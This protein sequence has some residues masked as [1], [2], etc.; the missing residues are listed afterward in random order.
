MAARRT[1]VD[2]VLHASVWLVGAA[3]VCGV[4]VIIIE[5]M[6]FAGAYEEGSGTAGNLSI[7]PPPSSPWVWGSVPLLAVLVGALAHWR[8]TPARFHNLVVMGGPRR[9]LVIVN[10]VVLGIVAGCLGARYAHGQFRERDYLTAVEG[11][12]RLQ[13]YAG[14]TFDRAALLE[15]GHDACDWL[16]HKRW[17][18]PPEGD[19]PPF[20]KDTRLPDVRGRDQPSPWSSWYI[21]SVDAQHPGAASAEEL[22]RIWVY[23]AAWTELCPFQNAVRSDRNGGGD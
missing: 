16:A 2:A 7:L 4:L 9:N 15:A 1:V 22:M 21:A 19:P 8:Y 12:A 6:L 5:L 18:E 3:L 11:S 13:R 23:Q 10:L 14:G 17:G 20:T